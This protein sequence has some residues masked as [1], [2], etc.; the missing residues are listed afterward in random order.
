MRALLLI[1]AVAAELPAQ[2]LS[3]DV[4][5]RGALV[6]TRR[7][8]EF[9]VDPP[10]SRL[11]L[12]P[13]LKG[14][15]EGGSEW[16]YL[17]CEQG[18][19][20]LD[21]AAPEF[22]D[23]SWR[24]GRGM[25]SPDAGKQAQHRTLWNQAEL[26]LR[27]H[28]DL[29]RKLPRAL[30]FTATHDDGIRIYC[31][32]QLVVTNAG[33]GN[34]NLYVVDDKAMA[35]LHR[36]DNVIAVQCTN[37]GGAQNCDVALTLVSTMPYGVR[38]SDD[39]LAVL[40]REQEAAD[41]V[42]DELF[43][44]FRPPPLLLQGELTDDQSAVRMPPG[45]LRE[46]GWQA[47]MDLGRG[48]GGGSMA[49]EL[50]RLYRVGDVFMKGR[51]EPA[52]VDGWQ[53]I[54]LQVKTSPEVLPRGDSKRFVDRYVKP[55][56]LYGV[57]GR[58][59]VRRRLELQQG[60]ARVA[61]FRT[62]MQLTLLRGKDWKEVAATLHQVEDWHFDQVRDGQDSVFRAN[63][64]K[65]LERGCQRMR[66][67]IADVGKPDLAA[68]PK[69]GNDS[70]HSGRIAIGLLALI[71]GGLPRDD[72]VVQR[73]MQE[74]R[75]R[76]LIDTYSLAN[77][78]MAFEAFHAPPNEF[79]DLKMGVI[80]RPR[81]R[82]VPAE[83]L[84]VMQRWTD[85]LLQN[86]DTRVDPAY[87]LRFNYTRDARY[88]HSVNQ[89]GLLGLYSAHLCGVDI[90]P[91]VWEAAGNHLIASQGQSR[92]KLDLD[93]VDYRTFARLQADPAARHTVV[94]L[95]VRPAGWSYGD[96]KDSG[97]ETP[98]YG[99]M[100]C[101]GITGLTICQAAMLD[102]PGQKRLRW[103]S[104]VQ[105][106]RNAGFGWLAERLQTRYHPGDIDRQ[107]HWIYYYLY[108]LERA[109]LLSG[110]AL[111]Q[112]RDWYFEGAMVLTMLQQ[113][114]GSWPAEL[115]YD[116]GYERNAMAILFLKQS[117]LPVLTGQ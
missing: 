42:R 11:K 74:L 54:E 71:K 58:L 107:Q 19:V 22:D 98:R 45:D 65:A 28:V 68:Q 113:D 53:T 104:D 34:R 85:Q 62:V 33:V 75:H 13:V 43:G 5:H 116:L 40:R 14:C 56:V 36:G 1:L 31:N 47:A 4:P 29:G 95:P 24:L 63:V 39:L 27:T 2:A 3:W 77:A 60:R 102:Y 115:H 83:D 26:C 96:A 78:L 73:C 109:A 112:D 86:I 49:F 7:T 84:S 37:T 93:L 117:T 15:T 76:H 52:D 70:H 59:T 67:D 25:F 64:A 69:D 8:E 32:G 92:S 89:Y 10:A 80:D 79:G 110:V 88:D 97:E 44:G 9:R 21:F 111:I 99:S 61:E 81:Q 18:A 105:N 57:D 50:P 90:S 48:L 91:Q 38:S 100:T 17:G 35:A 106:A 30:L 46:L 114:D 55:Y 6:Y 87:V 103:N 41:H 101:A 108:G 82:R 12:E 16:R 94:R 23:S 72:E 51:A 66:N 20:P